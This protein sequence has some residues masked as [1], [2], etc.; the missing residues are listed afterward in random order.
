MAS[1]ILGHFVKSGLLYFCVLNSAVLHPILV[2]R[3]RRH[4]PAQWNLIADK[5]TLILFQERT[6]F[7][8]FGNILALNFLREDLDIN[9]GHLPQSNK[10]TCCS[11]EVSLP[12]KT[13]PC[14]FTT[15]VSSCCRLVSISLLLFLYYRLENLQQVGVSAITHT[16]HCLINA[17]KSRTDCAWKRQGTSAAL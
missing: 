14:H 2:S 13:I 6:F 8:F 7:F 5:S 10:A 17:A 1:S 4:G 15:P 11:T 16:S 3:T 12:L 9:Y